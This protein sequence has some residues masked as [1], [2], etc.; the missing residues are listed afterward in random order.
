MSEQ[1]INDLVTYLVEESLRAA[2]NKIN[3]FEK[4]V[5]QNAEEKANRNQQQFKQENYRN[6]YDCIMLYLTNEEQ[7]IIEPDK[8]KTTGKNEVW[9]LKNKTEYKQEEIQE[10]TSKIIKKYGYWLEEVYKK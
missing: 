3:N 1:N 10:I 4:T 6:F 8:E 5:I 2:R 7:P 9:K